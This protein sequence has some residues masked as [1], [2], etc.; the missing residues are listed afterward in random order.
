MVDRVHHR[1]RCQPCYAEYR[2]VKGKE[3]YRRH[4]DRYVAK[5][6]LYRETHLEQVRASA[7]AIARRR[8]ND[9]VYC[10]RMRAAWRAGDKVRRA[11]KAGKLIRPEAC[12]DCKKVCKPEA[13]HYDYALPLKVRWL[14]RGC[15][16]RWDA[17]KPKALRLR[18]LSQN[19][20]AA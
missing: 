2:R 12:E 16:R 20:R 3:N 17:A 7:R 15:H 5:A 19:D 11:L 10:K 6:T 4:Q 9:P 18:V 1:T 8:R 13:A 14:C